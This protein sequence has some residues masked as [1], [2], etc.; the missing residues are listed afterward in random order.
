MPCGRRRTASACPRSRRTRARTGPAGSAAHGR[1]SG[2]R[3][4]PTAASIFRVVGAITLRKGCDRRCTR[5]SVGSGERRSD[6]L[7]SGC[8]WPGYLAGCQRPA[9]DASEYS[10]WSGHRGA[11]GLVFGSVASRRSPCWQRSRSCCSA[12]GAR[13]AP[14]PD[15]GR[16]PLHLVP[17]SRIRERERVRPGSGREAVNRLPG[18]PSARKQH[19]YSSATTCR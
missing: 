15:Q 10:F 2:G 3:A 14:H 13:F 1:S 19:A 8:P 16:V 4:T 7:G 11:R 5:S 6:R 12:I 17:A 18:A 9:E